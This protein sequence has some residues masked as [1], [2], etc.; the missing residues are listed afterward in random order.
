MTLLFHISDLHFGLED[1]AALAWFADCE[2]R[3]RPAAV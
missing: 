2:V 3:E 1:P